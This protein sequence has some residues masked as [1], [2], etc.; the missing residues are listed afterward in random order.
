MKLRPVRQ[1]GQLSDLIGLPGWHE[2]YYHAMQCKTCPHISLLV[3]LAGQRHQPNV[4]HATCCNTLL[5]QALLTVTIE[6]RQ[7]LG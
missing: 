4:L 5:P 6:E 1:P 2:D 3:R 7:P